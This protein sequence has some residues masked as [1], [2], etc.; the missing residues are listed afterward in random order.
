MQVVQPRTLLRTT[1]FNFS[2]ATER[3]YKSNDGS[4]FVETTW[5]TCEGFSGEK[6]SVEDIAKLQKGTM[7]NVKGRIRR[8][9]HTSADGERIT[10]YSIYV[11][12]LS[13]L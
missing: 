2:L 9:E 13:I 11:E 8:L 3:V 7:V 6:I 4:A 12:E 10:R 1:I 5:H